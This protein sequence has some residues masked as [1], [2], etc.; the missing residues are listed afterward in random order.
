MAVPTNSR[1]SSP[2]ET[3]RPSTGTRQPCS[4]PRAAL[5]CSFS[6]NLP[7]A[8]A[9]QEWDPRA[10]GLSVWLLSLGCCCQGSSSG[11]VHTSSLFMA[12]SYSVTHSP[13]GRLAW[14]CLPFS[15]GS[16]GHVGQSRPPAQAARCAQNP[17]AGCTSKFSSPVGLKSVFVWF[18]RGSL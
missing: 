13:A 15:G 12:E 3:P 9:S 7:V 6:L 11:G 2:P 5:T 8:D 1:T 10:G 4:Q 18:A 17:M 14:V 16:A